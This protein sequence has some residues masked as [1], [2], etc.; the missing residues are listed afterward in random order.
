MGLRVKEMRSDLRSKVLSSYLLNTLQGLQ[1]SKLP[2]EVRS[3]ELQS[4]LPKALLS[5]QRLRCVQDRVWQASV[6][7]AVQERRPALPSRLCAAQVRLGLQG[8]QGMPQAK[9]QHEV[10]ETT[11]LLGQLTHGHTITA[12]GKRRDRSGRLPL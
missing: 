2:D 8:A 12:I 5:R 4:G 11:R 1:H 6:Q 3:A 9:M 7:D 10:R